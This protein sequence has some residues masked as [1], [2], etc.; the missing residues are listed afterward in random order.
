M[1]QI[2]FFDNG[3]EFVGFR[4]MNSTSDYGYH[5]MY[6][7]HALFV[8]TTFM[9]IIHLKNML[10]AIMGQTFSD[11]N[12]VKDQI[13]IKNHLKFI[14]NNWYLHYI[15]FSDGNDNKLSNKFKSNY[16]NQLIKSIKYIV[17]AFFS[18]EEEQDDELINKLDD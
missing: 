9:T 10:V 11:R 6:V 13:R 1:M 5:G 7:I 12:P 15:A 17:V 16:E 18:K 14:I 4:K 3:S 8:V 2:G